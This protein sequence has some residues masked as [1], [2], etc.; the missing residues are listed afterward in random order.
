MPECN[1]RK[2]ERER[3]GREKDREREGKRKAKTL[4]ESQLDTDGRKAFDEIRS[5]KKSNRY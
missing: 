2:W 3:E 1:E 5:A 4:K